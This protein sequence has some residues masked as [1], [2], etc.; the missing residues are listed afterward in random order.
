[1]H[2]CGHDI[3]TASL[4]SVAKVLSEV[5]EQLAGT[6]VFIH[7]FCRRNCSWRSKTDD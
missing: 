1:M 6:V 7:Q 2:A 4:L 5:R 3:H